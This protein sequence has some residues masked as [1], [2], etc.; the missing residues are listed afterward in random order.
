MRTIVVA[1]DKLATINLTSDDTDANQCT[2]PIIIECSENLNFLPGDQLLAINEQSVLEKSISDVKKLVKTLI[3]TENPEPSLTFRVRTNLACCEL[4]FRNV[5]D[6]TRARF[7]AGSDSLKRTG[8]L[9]RK[10]PNANTMIFNQPN[11]NKSLSNSSVSSSSSSSMCSSTTDSTTAHSRSEEMDMNNVWLIHS[12]GYSAAKIFAKILHKNVTDSP[13]GGAV[14]FKVRLENG[15]LIEVNEEMLEKANPSPQFDYCEDISSLRFIN[16]T[17]ILHCV[18]QR[19]HTL[20]LIH[21]YIGSQSLLVL[22]PS[23]HMIEST[24]F[25]SIYN[26]KV[27]GMFKGCKQDDMPPHVYSYVQS[28]YRNML[29]SRQD[30]SIVLMGHSASGKTT[31]SKF[32]L[33]YLFKVASNNANFSGN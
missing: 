21:T 24:N 30:Q 9:R 25:R 16:E 18:R 7:G 5:C 32:I 31:N 17:S 11:L 1:L 23:R 6:G 28:V 33:N 15:N 20:K 2:S 26:D 14:R 4:V 13:T 10:Q 22:K 3:S 27:I 29:S 19:Y 8:S 12:N